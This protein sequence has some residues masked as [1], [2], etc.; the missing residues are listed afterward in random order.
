MSCPHDLAVLTVFFNPGGYQS[1]VANFRRFHTAL[2][3]Q[4]VELRAVEVAFGDDPFYVSE[5]QGV[6]PLRTQD[7][8]WQVERMI[9]H[10]VSQLPATYAKVAWVDADVLFENAEWCR[11]TADAL[12]T[13]PVVQPFSTAV[14]LDE[15]D[16]ECR[17]VP[18]IV[19]AAARHPHSFA[20]PRVAH[21]GFAWAARRELI[22]QHGVPDF[23]ILGGNDRVFS[24]AVYG[25]VWP[26]EMAHYSPPLQMRIQTWA[27]RF[28]A[29]VRA[30]ADSVDGT[31]YHL[32]H[33]DLSKRRYLERN[34]VLLREDFDPCTDIRIGR[35]G[36]WHW[37][38]AKP[39]LHSSVKEYFHS[40]QADEHFQREAT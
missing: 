31:V 39:R 2:M 19:S 29:T 18:G 23:C 14:W 21:P 33:G 25:L 10:C 7:V 36:A 30:A 16:K 40:L 35:D 9:N 15:N 32:F 26:R 13:Y 1:T 4:G 34:L 20:R 12:D 17:R 8:L 38:T 22:E 5:L 3:E 11:Q 27:Q 28:H 6:S 37:A 24:N